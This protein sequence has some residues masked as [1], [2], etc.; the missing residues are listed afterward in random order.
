MKM[1]L[2]EIIFS[3]ITIDTLLNGILY[4]HILIDLKCLYFD[5]MTKKTVEQNKSK[6][7]LVSLWKIINVIN[8]LGTINEIAKTHINVNKHIKIYYF[9]IKD[10]NL[11]YNLILSRL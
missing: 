2:K 7:F 4:I 3:L 11:E 5:M 8:K 9:Y 10:N 1:A 6:Q